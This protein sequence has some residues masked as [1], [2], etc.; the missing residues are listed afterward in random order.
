MI[1]VGSQV[2]FGLICKVMVQLRA[3][4]LRSTIAQM[5]LVSKES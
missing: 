3:E 1:D 5:I 4:G 2:R